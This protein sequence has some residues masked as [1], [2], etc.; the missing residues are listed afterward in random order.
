MVFGSREWIIREAG[1]L[2]REA[3]PQLY[4]IVDGAAA[5]HGL[6]KVQC[7]SE[8]AIRMTCVLN[9]VTAESFR[10][11]LHI[12]MQLAT[13]LAEHQG[14]EGSENPEGQSRTD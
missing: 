2:A 8:D 10:L 5:K 7:S 1:T 6:A 9:D 11:G 13:R 12:A 4:S 14:K 3:E